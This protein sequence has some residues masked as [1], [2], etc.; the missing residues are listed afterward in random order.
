[1][2]GSKQTVSVAQIERRVADVVELYRRLEFAWAWM[3]SY[4]F[5]GTYIQ[6]QPVTPVASRN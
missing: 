3:Q 2:P 4:Q 6:L 1:M 5:P